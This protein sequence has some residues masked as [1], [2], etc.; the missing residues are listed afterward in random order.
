MSK[1]K[2]LQF[3][4]DLPS[5]DA[6]SPE[7]AHLVGMVRRRNWRRGADWYASHFSAEAKVRGESCPSY[8]AP[9][10]PEIPARMAGLIPDARLLMCVRDPVDRA[11]SHYLMHMVDRNERRTVDEALSD[12]LSPYIGQSRYASR[13]EA[14]LE[15]FPRSRVMVVDHGALLNRR[16][17]TVQAVFRFAEID[18]SFWSPRMDRELNPTAR[19]NARRRLMFRA[20]KLPVL[21]QAQKL[22]DDVRWLVERL[23]LSRTARSRPALDPGLRAELDAELSGEFEPLRAHAGEPLGGWP[24]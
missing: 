14:F 20:R 12:P 15:R 18:D 24:D 3:F 6:V 8:M 16:R 13:L 22:P 9:W 2:E 10:Y 5:P 11:I 1:P 23:G 7:S 21:R 4:C 19:R 17:E